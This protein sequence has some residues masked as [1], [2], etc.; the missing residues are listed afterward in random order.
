LVVADPSEASVQTL[1]W[2]VQQ[3]YSAEVVVVHFASQR[4]EGWTVHNARASFVA[5]LARGM[6]RPLLMLAEEDHASALDYK[7]LLYR[8]PSAAECRTRVQY[9]LSRELGQVHERVAA[10]RDEAEALRFSTELRSVDL[11]EY[12]A[13]NEASGLSRY[14]VETATIREVLSGASRVYVGSKGSGKSATAMQGAIAIESDKRQ[15][16]C[17]IKPAG[18]DLDGL[19]R[20]LR[21][22]E[23]RDARGYIAESLWKFLLATELA[24]AVERDLGRRVA[25]V[26]PNGPEWALLEFIAE[27][28]D[29][30]K[31][32][33]ATRLERAVDKML[34]APTTETIADERTAIAEALHAG[35]LA[36]LRDV[37]GPALAVRRRTFIIIDNLDKAWDAGAEATQLARVI[38]GLLS[39][40]DAFRHDLERVG[41]GKGVDVS[42]SLFLRSDIFQA[43]AKQAREP[44]KLP[45]RHLL[46]EE[47]VQLL[48]I[49]EE[50]Y[51]ASRL[52][53]VEQGELWSRFFCESV[54]G[55]PV[56]EWLLRICI[57]RPRD[58]LYLCRAAIDQAVT[59]RHAVVEEVDLV[60]AERQYSLF[61]F[62]AVA[63]ECQ[64]RF[65]NSEVVLLEFAGAPTGLTLA[66][67]EAVL[68]S[69]GVAT[70]DQDDVVDALRDV[71]FLGVITGSGPAAFT[72]TPREKQKANVLARKRGS[73]EDDDARYE[74]HRAYWAYLELEHSW[75]T[76]NLGV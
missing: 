30:I 32:D 22:Y 40:M 10:V 68:S 49:V 62:E 20:L 60:A 39:C 2:Y 27:N 59:S 37:L 18:Y 69:G 36:S 3:I 42:L 43:V 6:R 25:G 58:L 23:Q 56:R 41:A 50:R 5:G 16:A 34:T 45:V 26:V 12:V 29:W 35:P 8:Y 61:A 47:Q 1:A 76:L 48:D 71:G 65:A 11:G 13:E 64:Q 74:I 73:D 53:D 33:F 75:R 70:G 63:V 46:W 51:V 19:V 57:P 44:D 38:L 67:L 9:W 72:D 24:L 15:L 4:R 31:A 17:V 14:F 52:G 28:S 21:G 55:T 54:N 7:D 66:Q